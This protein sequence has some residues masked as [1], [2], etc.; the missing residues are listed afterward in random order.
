MNQKKTFETAQ[1]L[2]GLFHEL[3][4]DRSALV[5][6]IG[7]GVLGDIA[8]FAAATYMRGVD[9]IIAPST[10]L[11]Q[12]DSSVGGKL[13]F[14]FNKTKNLIGVFA[15]PQAVCIDTQ[16]LTSLSH[17][18]YLDGFAEIIKH[19]AIADTQLFKMLGQNAS[20]LQNV[21]TDE[22]KEFIDLL[23]RSIEVK[24]RIVE[25]DEREKTGTRKLLNFGHTFGHAFESF[26]HTHT[27]SPLS[28]G[29]AVCLGMIAESRA[30]V[31]DKIMSEDSYSA[32][33]ETITAFGFPTKLSQP[34]DF[35]ALLKLIQS[36][37]KNSHGSVSWSLVSEI[38]TAH[39]DQKLSE[40]ALQEGF[41]AVLPS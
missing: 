35:E 36:D 29:R 38:G 14:N 18:I 9:F 30:A 8:G 41:Q 15:Q 21:P 7:G 39:A 28:H 3:R 19:G 24:R 12:T 40:A 16:L 6:I 23:H 2:W 32:L 34:Y 11:S 25:V 5:F 1:N 26:S 4:L 33:V 31:K 22:S 27:E 20:T 13:G 10:L 17:G 37:K